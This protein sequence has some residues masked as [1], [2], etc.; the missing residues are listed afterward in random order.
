MLP[1]VGLDFYM[2]T[3]WVKNSLHHEMLIFRRQEIL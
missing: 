1:T 2:K 3:Q